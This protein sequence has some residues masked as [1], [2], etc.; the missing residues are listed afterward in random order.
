MNQDKIGKFIYKLRTERNLSQ[1]QLADMIPITRQAVSKWERGESIPDS[2][3]LLRLS[4][5]FNVTINELLNGERLKEN[6]IKELESTTLNILDE[7][8][9]K[10][11]KLKRNFKI[12]ITII[13]ALLLAFLSYY[14]IT[15]YNSIKVYIISGSSEKF[16][17]HDGILLKTNSKNYLKMGKLRYDEN[18]KIN[19]IKFYYKKNNKKYLIVEDKDITELDIVDFNGYDEKIDINRMIDNSYLEINYDDNKTEI[20]KLSFKRTFTNDEFIT[21]KLKKYTKIQKDNKKEVQAVLNEEPIEEEKKEEAKEEPHEEP[22]VESTPPE[23]SIQQTPI[24]VEPVQ[25]EPKV[26]EEN[27]TVDMLIPIIKENGMPYLDSY[28]YEIEE[29][30]IMFMYYEEKNQITVY[31]GDDLL[32]DYMINENRYNCSPKY[33]DSCKETIEETIKKYLK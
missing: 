31:E 19:N 3:T 32:W 23:T 12:S 25:E 14:F 21:S 33:S 10:S 17:I 16:I 29:D 26:E 9:K 1:Y 18:I 7:S 5:I 8:N 28:I 2:S 13:T 11:K 20:I 22:Q 15:S 24:I 4:D 30:E 27:L 6:S